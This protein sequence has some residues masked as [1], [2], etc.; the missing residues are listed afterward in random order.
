M[1]HGVRSCQMFEIQKELPKSMNWWTDCQMTLK[2]MKDEIYIN[3]NMKIL[4]ILQEDLPR[5]RSV[6]SLTHTV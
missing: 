6:Q 5:Q 1:I 2:L 3:Q 4:Q